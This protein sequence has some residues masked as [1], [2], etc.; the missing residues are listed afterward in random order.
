MKPKSV[1]TSALVFAGSLAHCE[2]PTDVST[3]VIST[4]L[5]LVSRDLRCKG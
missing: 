3:P 2:K 5:K 1:L 4:L